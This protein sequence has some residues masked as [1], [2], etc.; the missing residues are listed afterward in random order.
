MALHLRDNQ[1]RG[2]NAHLQSYFQSQG[3]WSSFHNKYFAY[4]S[5]EISAHLPAGYLVDL[6]QSLQ[7]HE[8][9]PD[10]G[11]RLR[12]PEPD[13]S[14]Y[15]TGSAS[16]SGQPAAPS[17]T[18]ATLEQPIIETFEFNEDLYYTALVIY[19]VVENVLLGRPIVQLE[20]LSP[21]NKQG[22][23]G[24]TQYKDKRYMLLKSGLRLVE[25]DFLNETPS[26][27]KGVPAYPHAAGSYPYHITVNDPTPDIQTGISRTYSFGVDT[28]LSPI[29]IPLSGSQHITLDF[30]GVYDQTFASLEAYSLRVDYTHPP[31]HFERY[32]PADQERIRAV[33]T[34]AAQAV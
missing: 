17:Q 16:S 28:P 4:L 14:I 18:I 1:Y 13:I 24:Y 12:R 3:G 5:D 2:I 11:Q 25:V 6:E 26:P 30:G 20:L 34:R 32:S 29:V 21:T 31:Q 19:E 7:I 22:G 23:D 9:H 33:M 15:Q 8:F 10:T 27:V